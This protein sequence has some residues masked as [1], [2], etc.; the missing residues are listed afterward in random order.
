M[1]MSSPASGTH[2]SGSR[3]SNGASAAAHA[4]GA[5]HARPA[6]LP[7][8][9]P[10]Q[11]IKEI[12]RLIGWLKGQINCLRDAGLII[13]APV[14]GVPTR[15]PGQQL[16]RDAFAPIA[17]QLNIFRHNLDRA[18]HRNHLEFQGLPRQKYPAFLNLIPLVNT[19][20]QGLQRNAIPKEDLLNY[21]NQ[22]NALIIS[23]QMQKA[24]EAARAKQRSWL[25]PLGM[26]AD[27]AEA[28]ALKKLKS[29]ISAG[30][31]SFFTGLISK[32]EEM[33][34][35]LNR[36]LWET[37]DPDFIN[38]ENALKDY[39]TAENDQLPRLSEN[40]G[41]YFSRLSVKQ[42]LNVDDIAQ[43]LVDSGLTYEELEGIIYSGGA[44]S[45]PDAAR[46]LIFVQK[47]LQR[48]S[49]IL[50]PAVRMKDEI[51]RDI[52]A[53]GARALQVKAELEGTAS[54][55]KASLVGKSYKELA[56][57]LE[58]VPQLI[59]LL[60]E[61]RPAGAAAGAQPNINLAAANTLLAKIQ[62][63][64]TR[65]LIDDK[66]AFIDHIL[67]KV[68]VKDRDQV[69]AKIR[70]DIGLLNDALRL[71][72]PAQFNGTE[73][74]A[75]IK[76]GLAGI[77]RML[78]EL[79][80]KDA[81]A[82]ENASGQIVAQV[83]QVAKTTKNEL[84]AAAAQT[85]AQL[86]DS[87]VGQAHPALT[88]LHTQI[89]QLKAMLAAVPPAQ[90]GAAAPAVQP[91]LGPANVAN[92]LFAKI[93]TNLKA[94]YDERDKIVDN[95]VSKL[96]REK[97]ERIRQEF[98]P[99]FDRHLAEMQ[100]PQLPLTDEFIRFINFLFQKEAGM[101]QL[102]TDQLVQ[103]VVQLNGT[104]EQVSTITTNAREALKD[105]KAMHD[106]A[107]EPPPAGAAAEPSALVRLQNITTTVNGF[108]PIVGTAVEK[109]H[110]MQTEANRPPP[111]GAVPEP[112]ALA[113]L[114]G[115]AETTE[116]VVNT[117]VRVASHIIPGLAQATPAIAAAAAAPAAAAPLVGRVA[118][119]AAPA[120]PQPIDPARVQ[121]IN[122]K[123][124]HY[125][126]LFKA[127]ESKSKHY[128][129][130]LERNQTI[131]PFIFISQVS[132]DRKAIEEMLADGQ[133]YGSGLERQDL[134][135]LKAVLE[136]IHTRQGFDK[137]DLLL[138]LSL[139]QPMIKTLDGKVNP[140]TGTA[141]LILRKF[142]TALQDA[143]S[144]GGLFIQEG[145]YGLT[146]SA[147][148][149]ALK[150]IYNQLKPEDTIARDAIKELA[151]KAQL[152][153]TTGQSEDLIAAIDHAADTL[154]SLGIL[155][156]GLSLTQGDVKRESETEITIAKHIRTINQ[157]LNP[158]SAKPSE[159]AAA[160]LIEKEKEKLIEN[161]ALFAVMSNVWT[162]TCGIKATL[163]FN[164]I[165]QKSR[166]EK[167]ENVEEALKT[168]FYA[169]IDEHRK[170]VGTIQR[171]WAKVVFNIELWAARGVIANFISNMLT[172][173]KKYLEE[174][175]AADI[176]K[177]IL[178]NATAYAAALNTILRDYASQNKSIYK[179]RD[180]YVRD[181][182]SS[183]DF[184][185]G[186]T[187]EQL[188]EIAQ[189]AVVNQFCLTNN[190]AGRT[191]GAFKRYGTGSTAKTVVKW[192]TIPITG[193]FLSILWVLEK[194]ILDPILRVI[195]RSALQNNQAIKTVLENVSN[196]HQDKHGYSYQV[197]SM[198]YD[199][200]LKVWQDIK[201]NKPVDNSYK[202]DAMNIS[203]SRIEGLK[204]LLH[205]FFEA[206]AKDQFPTS[207]KQYDARHH[208]SVIDN[209]RTI[210]ED[211]ITRGVIDE[212]VERLAVALEKS[213]QNDSFDS[214]LVKLLSAG[215]RS[216]EQTE[217]ITEAQNKRLEHDLE[218]LSNT[219]FHELIRT[220]INDQLHSGVERHQHRLNA[221]IDQMK[222]RYLGFFREGS[223]FNR[224]ENYYELFELYKDFYNNVTEL[225][226]AASASPEIGTSSSNALI[227]MHQPLL[228][229]LKE[230]GRLLTIA[231]N[232][233]E[234]FD[235][236][237]FRKKMDTELNKLAQIA[238]T[239]I[240]RIALHNIE[241]SFIE[242]FVKFARHSAFN[243]MMKRKQG[244]INLLKKPYHGV[245]LAHKLVLLPF[246]NKVAP[247]AVKHAKHPT[248]W[249]SFQN[250][251]GI[252]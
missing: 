220:T 95:I 221:T 243:L 92:A 239:N 167:P 241:P 117:A 200:L 128:Q 44:I 68:P 188:Y 86:K 199:Q 126:T 64:Y 212:V 52:S 130:L 4:H 89:P 145:A 20:A 213:V 66:D 34:L 147:L 13:D 79:Y 133:L 222:E 81:G 109:L 197:T 90:A 25:N 205:N 154:Q 182:M 18:V 151:E 77:K 159:G 155:I 50:F 158:S 180:S 179:G 214:M 137:T 48:K 224:A 186:L 80:E 41:S 100:N 123:V 176:K 38:L 88:E 31:D 26:I 168:H 21:L 105:V 78:D 139:V 39:I 42:L 161:A 7:E 87:I 16:C 227:Q 1:S 70:A 192:V 121:P 177:G 141:D 75:Q 225:L 36:L 97:Q 129:D 8:H 170:T 191:W 246:D 136:G 116:R 204:E 114:Q 125:L 40:I 101:V 53:A 14:P 10:E 83:K 230:I 218:S 238:Q 45:K 124:N 43:S 206:V 190:K 113:R 23:Y 149:T 115:T 211:L 71:T 15:P 63:N 244:M 228:V 245:G 187:Q 250:A 164:Q 94:V 172:A 6:P 144:S 232:P 122:P 210:Y 127:L 102:A 196:S 69:K 216:F 252:L 194:A 184:N 104:L 72:L 178:T 3:L 207:D 226:R 12:Y 156:N 28:A 9:S 106:K 76:D 85:T 65:I 203:G 248:V 231:T 51:T 247:S 60:D 62:A 217:E 162:N 234:R 195:V 98:G 93:K 208:A 166:R 174:N 185:D 49:G 165:I 157:N 118:A 96:P 240:Q 143:L 46:A 160:E 59:Q 229:Q 5:A 189:K 74:F 163:N 193:A 138:I 236:N 153:Y 169:K 233:P 54:Q 19:L 251:L 183:A 148:M 82:L 30:L 198:I 91:D 235:N 67:E 24:Q 103:Q 242:P 219:I 37:P 27:G 249:S 119:Q 35:G 110:T 202:M 171:A 73:H 33:R 17:E 99:Y 120:Q 47:H 56:E 112:S 209:V 111:P 152:A 131:D 22:V 107:N 84:E 2:A 215:N 142:K 146:A 61:A 134:E 140:L 181:V 57:L 175:D 173:V 29:E 150:Y 237:A 11:N 58:Q 135:T 201:D 32:P 223:E 55:L 108:M 132:V